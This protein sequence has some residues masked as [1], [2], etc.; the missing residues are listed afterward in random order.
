[1][2]EQS[3]STATVAPS[4]PIRLLDSWIDFWMSIFDLVGS[5]FWLGRDTG[6]WMWRAFVL[7][8]V[9]IG[10]GAITSQ[11]VRV[12][13]RSISIVMLVSGSIGIILALQTS[14]TLEQYGQTDKVANL[15]GVSV[16]R[17]LGPLIAAIVMVGFAGASIAAEI[18]TM[19]VGEEVEA[20]EAMGLNPVRYLVVP[21]LAATVTSLLA[22]AVVSNL[23]AVFFGMVIGT[24]VLGIPYDLYVSN[25]ISQLKM[26]DFLTGLMKAGVFGLLLGLIACYNGL[27][28]TGGAAGVGKAT[29]ET[30]VQ[31]VIFV[32]LSDLF[33][34]A[35]FYAIG[36][37]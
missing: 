35:I 4:A 21:R 6:E 15:V 37:T 34:S 28:V 3:E 31:T 16:F 10:S 19:V 32:I 9:R 8:R 7:R 27:R 26:S 20:L 14:P 11:L 18:G 1:M 29:T 2:A 36:W 12:G 22:L 23:T 24:L 13:V 5:L 33:F 17:E 30:V 25:T